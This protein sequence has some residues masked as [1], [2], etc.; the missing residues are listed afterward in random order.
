LHARGLSGQLL[1]SDCLYHRD[2]SDILAISPANIGPL[3]FHPMFGACQILSSVE[4]EE[5]PFNLLS[6][7]QLWARAAHCVLLVQAL[8][9][10]VY[11]VKGI[12]RGV[13]LRLLAWGRRRCLATSLFIQFGACIRLKIL[14]QTWDIDRSKKHADGYQKQRESS[15]LNTYPSPPNSSIKGIVGDRAHG[16]WPTS[17]S[18]SSSPIT[19]TPNSRALSSFDPASLP[20]TT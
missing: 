15:H 12:T 18:N 8:V 9:E 14:G 1:C 10:S 2:I 19:L 5:G 17:P 3:D 16:L 11:L 7:G 6:R 4:D 20:A 13:H